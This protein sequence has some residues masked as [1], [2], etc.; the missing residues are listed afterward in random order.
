MTANSQRGS[1][2]VAEP[3]HT[4]TRPPHLNDDNFSSSQTDRHASSLAGSASQCSPCPSLA[5][6]EHDLKDLALVDGAPAA[7]YPPSLD[8]DSTVST[9]MPMKEGLKSEVASI[10]WLLSKAPGLTQQHGLTFSALQ[11]LDYENS[12]HGYH[13]DLAAW[14][15]DEEMFGHE[16]QEAT[17]TDSL[18]VMGKAKSPTTSCTGSS[19]DMLSDFVPIDDTDQDV[20]GTGAAFYDIASPQL[21]DDIDISV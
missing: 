7:R 4:R 17:L 3:K 5:G 14:C 6:I 11:A 16:P 2:E 20:A 8:T 21:D 19:Y 13:R 9:V 15:R 1:Q 12:V 18:L 10:T